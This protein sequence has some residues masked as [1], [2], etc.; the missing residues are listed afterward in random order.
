MVESASQA[1]GISIA[2]T[3]GRL[4]PASVSNSTALSSE[5]V[6]LPP[7]RITGKDLLDIVAEQV[8]FQHGFARVHPVDVARAPC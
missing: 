5:A 8:R 2:I 1:S 3:C 6:S 7:G 4:R